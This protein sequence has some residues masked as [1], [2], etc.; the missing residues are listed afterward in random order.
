MRLVTTALCTFFG[1]ILALPAVAQDTGTVTGSVRIDHLDLPLVDPGDRFGEAVT[2]LGDINGDGFLEIAVG[3]PG[4][5]SGGFD[6]GAVWI[7]SLEND[8]S[9]YFSQRITYPT[10]AIA[11]HDAFGTSVT[12]IGDLDYDG[13]VDLAVGAPGD[14][15][16][17]ADGGAVW[18]L[19]MNPNGTARDSHK[20]D[21][22][23][24]EAGAGLG[25]SVAGL[26]DLNFDGIPDIAAG[27]P[28]TDAG[29]TDRG[30][31]WIFNMRR[32]GSLL[33]RVEQAEGRL[34]LSGLFDD[35]DRYG[36]SIAGTGD[37]NANNYRDMVVGAAG[38]DDGGTDRGALWVVK[39][40]ANG[41]INA[42]SKISEIEAGFG[43]GL[44]DGDGLGLAL[45]LPGD[46]DGD[47]VLELAI[48]APGDDDG[49]TDR[50]AIW[51]AF[52]DSVET[53]VAKQKISDTDGGFLASLAD[54]DGLGSSIGG[55]G[56]LDGDGRSEI[57]VGLPA[58]G[59]CGATAGRSTCCRSTGRR[60]SAATASTTPTRS[61]TTAR[62]MPTTALSQR[63]LAR[64]VWRR[65]ALGADGGVRRR[66]REL[67][68][69]TRRLQDGLLR[70][71]L[72]RWGH[73]PRQRRGL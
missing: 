55:V 59:G 49:G 18:V 29:G 1:L 22:Y 25:S 47:G 72:R 60:R 40:W 68:H 69:D 38:D 5:D 16:G 2:P 36:S 52:L 14:D 4:D 62:S 28:G 15:S 7:L 67:G 64:A 24:I 3:A 8:G 50:G 20:L 45:G 51:I 41:T 58:D 61:A 21:N 48:G 6:R 9:I 73:R 42:I 44:D 53:V 34:G 33:G 54:G 11:D 66:R 27:A 17:R 32:D 37:L 57:A 56:D 39:M 26:G 13:I 30:A 19:Y 31:V 12:A 63:L 23:F 46:I 10:V 43:T 71:V 35:G 70:T 65:L